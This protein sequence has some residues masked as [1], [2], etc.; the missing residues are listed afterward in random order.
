MQ[1]ELLRLGL[2]FL[3]SQL[4]HRAPQRKQSR[5]A[6]ALVSYPGRNLLLRGS[7][8]LSSRVKAPARFQTQSSPSRYLSPMIDSTLNT[9]LLPPSL[10]QLLS[11]IKATDLPLR[12][13]QHQRFEEEADP[14]STGPL[15]IVRVSS[16]SQVDSTVM[17]CMAVLK[18]EGM[19]Y[20]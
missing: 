7:T 16:S 3:R 1:V 20:L 8:P 18:A 10:L 17:T 12:L 9:T 2:F 15:P 19:L 5:R 6:A 13:P 11:K 4:Q 14:E